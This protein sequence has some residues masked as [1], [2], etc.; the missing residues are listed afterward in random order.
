MVNGMDRC[1]IPAGSAYAGL[2]RD[3]ES[4]DE[5][6]ESL[7]DLF[8]EPYE[9]MSSAN[10]RHPPI[11]EIASYLPL[12]KRLGHVPQAESER[13]LG[14]F[15]E[16][17]G[18]EEGLSIGNIVSSIGNAVGSALTSGTAQQLLP[19]AGLA[20]GSAIGGPVGGA[21]GSQVATAAGSAIAGK[22]KEKKKEPSK[23]PSQY[24]ASAKKL[25]QLTQNPMI[26]SA[27]LSLALG[28]KGAKTLP[29]GNSGKQVPVS[30]LLKLFSTVASHASR[31]ADLRETA[32]GL[33]CN[34]DALTGTSPRE[35]IKELI[36]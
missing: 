2:A 7:D 28:K 10:V 27:I 34:Y 18:Y 36:N 12:D 24:P 21:V 32:E 25:L 23:T 31:T 1:R 30:Q 35:L 14:H 5:T 6:Y 20:A 8:E 11:A 29:L 33:D 17:A 19:V 4:N 9:E 26:L 13:I 16:S 15:I 22:R 3:V